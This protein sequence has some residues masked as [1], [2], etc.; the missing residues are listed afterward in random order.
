M[1][2][3]RIS[4]LLLV[5]KQNGTVTS[6]ESVAVS[7]NAKHLT[8]LSSHSLVFTQMNWKLT[9]PQN[10]YSSFVYNY[11]DVATTKLS[12]SRWVVDKQTLIRSYNGLFF[13]DK[14][15]WAL[16]PWEDIEEAKCTLLSGRSQ[17]EKAAYCDS[18]YTTFCAKQNWRNKK[19]SDFQGLGGGGE[20]RNEQ[21]EQGFLMQWH[22]SV[23]Y[24]SGWI[25]VIIH[26]SEPIECAPNVSPNVNY[27]LYNNLLILV[28]Q[29]VNGAVQREAYPKE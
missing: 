5:G 19:T 29:D 10:V 2:N 17:S 7:Y 9:S 26:L 25:H 18:S 23:F 28:Q 13:S 22:Y 14:E 1:W 24:H 27:R 6:K 11:Q 20:G 21:V 16:Q 4:H 12:F 3:N 8:M 15:K